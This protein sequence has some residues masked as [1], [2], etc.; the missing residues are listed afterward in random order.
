MN[1]VSHHKVHVYKTQES[2]QRE[3]V[4]GEGTCGGGGRE[5]WRSGSGGREK[6]MWKR[7][8]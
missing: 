2:V 6:M 7:E 3:V 1:K 5:M 8:G 4:V